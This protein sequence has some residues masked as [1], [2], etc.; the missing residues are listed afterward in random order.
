MARGRRLPSPSVASRIRTGLCA[1]LLAAPTVLAFFSGGFFD[2]PRLWAATCVWAGLA[3]AVALGAR[4][5]PASPSGRACVAG[6]AGL[7]ALDGGIDR[8]GA[9][10]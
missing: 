2:E 6:L 1:A 8:L 5:L 3:L 4:P 10:P 7:T 9:G